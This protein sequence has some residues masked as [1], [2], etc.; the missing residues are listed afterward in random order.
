MDSPSINQ[1][2]VGVAKSEIQS[3]VPFTVGDKMETLSALEFE[4]L[5]SVFALLAAWDEEERRKD[6]Q[7]ETIEPRSAGLP[8]DMRVNCM[9]NGTEGPGL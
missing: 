6:A 1:K 3:D 4:N 9:A 5:V 2:P 7:R 8:G